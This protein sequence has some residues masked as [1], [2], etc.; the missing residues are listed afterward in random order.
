MISET[1]TPLHEF[2]SEKKKADEKPRMADDLDLP[3][4]DEVFLRARGW[5]YW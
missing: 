3:L 4:D 1:Y 5:E 2:D